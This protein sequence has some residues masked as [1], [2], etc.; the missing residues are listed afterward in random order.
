M[1][2]GAESIEA[3]LSRRPDGQEKPVE[4]EAATGSFEKAMRTAE[5]QV[6]FDSFKNGA[7]NPSAF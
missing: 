5:K 6:Q 7:N 4:A 2:C 1:R 3:E